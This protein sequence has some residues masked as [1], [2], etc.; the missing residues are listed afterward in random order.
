[1]ITNDGKSVIKEFFGGQLKEIADQIVLGSGTTAASLTDTALATLISTLDVKSINADLANDRIVF[2]ATIPAG[3]SLTINEIG[4]IRRG[5]TDRLVARSVLS[6]P[7]VTDA[8]LP[9]DIEYSLRI[10][11]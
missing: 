9:T 5:T 2:R 10:T 6:T 11:V 8:D 1:M 3:V 4:L 7:N